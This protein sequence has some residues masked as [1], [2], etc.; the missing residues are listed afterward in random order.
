MYAVPNNLDQR[1]T[2]ASTAWSRRHENCGFSKKV[3]VVR[4]IEWPLLKRGV[5]QPGMGVCAYEK[6]ADK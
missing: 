5:R 3:V 2:I 4:P 6:N 1:R